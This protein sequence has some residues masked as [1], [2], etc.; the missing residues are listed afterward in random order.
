ML[1]ISNNTQIPTLGGLMNYEVWCSSFTSLEWNIWKIS[2]R[3]LSSVLCML[4]IVMLSYGANN[5]E[6]EWMAR[7]EGTFHITSVWGNSGGG[8][9]NYQ[10]STLMLLTLMWSHAKPNHHPLGY[11]VRGWDAEWMRI[12]KLSKQKQN[13]KTGAYLLGDLSCWHFIYVN[14]ECYA[15]L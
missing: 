14:I 5:G 11:P 3:V 4:G 7:T 2:N 13:R 12:P 9:E 8:N 15:S 10:S 1:V 6:T